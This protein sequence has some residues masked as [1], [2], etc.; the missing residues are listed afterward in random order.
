MEAADD[1]VLLERNPRSSPLDDLAADRNEQCF[2]R[3]PSYV[4]GYGVCE[5]SRQCFTMRAIHASII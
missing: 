1:L 5:N 3:R 4:G 2:D